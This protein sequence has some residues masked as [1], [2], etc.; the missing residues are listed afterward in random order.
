MK[1]CPEHNKPD[2]K[3]SPMEWLWC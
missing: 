2:Y 1:V 3:R